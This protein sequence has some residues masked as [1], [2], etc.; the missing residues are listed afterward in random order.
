MGVASPY[1]AT[2]GVDVPPAPACRRISYRFVK[3]SID[4]VVASAALLVL[5]PLLAIVALAVRLSSPG[6]VFYRWEVVGL[7][8]Q[9]FDGYKFRTMVA[10]ADKLREALMARNEMTGPVMK[11][12]D[13]PRITPVG[14]ILRRFSIDELPQL[15]SVVKGDMSLVGPRPPLRR[16]Y[17]QFA[18]WQRRKLS[19]IPG[20][21]CLWQVSGRNE[22]RDF[23]QWVRLDLE[24]IDN[25]SL[26]LD[27]RILARTLPA[28]L[29]RRGAY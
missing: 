10:D 14:R 2:Y 5:S 28:V 20:L 21:T 6:T 17:L 7:G 11:I 13:D 19:V 18:P 12:R 23:D 8:G 26:W 3:R 24:Y 15:W 1:S 4:L 27:A 22:I 16:E 25:W 29:S 9:P